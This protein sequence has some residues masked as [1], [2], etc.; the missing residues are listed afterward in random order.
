MLSCSLYEIIDFGLPNKDPSSKRYS[1]FPND[2]TIW[3]SL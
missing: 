2:L 1:L 3:N